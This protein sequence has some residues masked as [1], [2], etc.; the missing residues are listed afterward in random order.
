MDI[1]MVVAYWLSGYEWFGDVERMRGRADGLG[2]TVN[3]T[4]VCCVS[5]TRT[6]VGRAQAARPFWNEH[7]MLTWLL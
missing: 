3:D 6:K 4:Q 7:A 2:M 1:G 5:G